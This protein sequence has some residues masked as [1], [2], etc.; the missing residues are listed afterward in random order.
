[1]R[2]AVERSVSDYQIAIE[3]T[4]QAMADYTEAIR[5]DAGWSMG[6]YRRGEAHLFAARCELGS[7]SFRR[8]S[9]ELTEAIQDL[10]HATERN[11]TFASAFAIRAVAHFLL[12]HGEESEVDV[13]KAASLG[14]DMATLRKA[15]QASKS[16][17]A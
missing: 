8:A 1:L 13:E 4:R 15:I 14:T 9:E 6:Y 10:T 11:P 5:L 17:R 16:W 2:A 12:D 3:T 7:M